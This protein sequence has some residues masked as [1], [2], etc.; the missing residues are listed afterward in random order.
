MVKKYM[1]HVGQRPKYTRTKVGAFAQL[2]AYNA[3]WR[4][5]F[6]ANQ[7]NKLTQSQI[8]REGKKIM[9]SFGFTVNY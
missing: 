2:D 8:F 4:A 7:N 6:L 5:F 9:N 1:F 3:A